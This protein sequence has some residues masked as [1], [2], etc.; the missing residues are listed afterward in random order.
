MSSAINLAANRTIYGS[1]G[2]Q[3]PRN[4]FGVEWPIGTGFPWP[5]TGGLGFNH[6]YMQ[7]RAMER[8][9]GLG[10]NVDVFV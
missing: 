1:I 7:T 5:S 10:N 8:A 4:D 6:M 9:A 3:P 2:A